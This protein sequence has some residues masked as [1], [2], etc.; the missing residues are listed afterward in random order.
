[1][2]AELLNCG[3]SEFTSGESNRRYGESKRSKG[4]TVFQSSF[5][6]RFSNPQS[7]SHAVPQS[8]G[9]QSGLTLIELIVAISILM[10]LTGAAMPVVRMRI[11]RDR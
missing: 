4:P 7:R 5:W 3:T 8:R 1:M 11:Q 6:K 10:I 9:R 2:I